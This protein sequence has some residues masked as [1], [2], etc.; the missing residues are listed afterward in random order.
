MDTEIGPLWTL[1]LLGG[2]EVRTADG[3][4][5]TPPGRKTRAL[6]ACL[7]LPRGSAWSREQLTALFWGDR[8]EEQARGSLREALVKLRRCLGE[9]SPVQ[10]SR[11]TIALDPA[12]IG[13]D[14][15]EFA[16]L[17][18]TGELERAADLYRG[19]LLE[20]LSPLNAGFE[21]WLLVERA[22]L[23]DLAV[24]VFSKLLV[25]RDG[26]LAAMA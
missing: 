14:A 21:D 26:E 8:D 15:V 12:V 24:D 22:R 17:A 5:V 16:R 6:L 23:H 13:V 11:E 19:E 25:A 3:R 9:P 1:R 20:G 2:L 18:K 7:A 10:A 4:D